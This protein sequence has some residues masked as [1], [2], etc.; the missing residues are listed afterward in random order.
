MADWRPMTPDEQ[1][2]CRALG[3]VRYPVASPPKRLARSL[4]G[5]AES[6]PAQITDAQ[7]SVLWMMVVRFRRQ[8]A[9]R[10]LI[11]LARE[12]VGGSI[13]RSKESA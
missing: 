2:A 9:D 11:T 6:D 1:R 7:A 12:Q 4:A 5:Q 10:S 3:K 13:L 8:I